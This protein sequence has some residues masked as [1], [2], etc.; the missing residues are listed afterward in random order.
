MTD[1]K[2]R[3]LVERLCQTVGCPLPCMGHE[4]TRKTYAV[5]VTVVLSALNAEES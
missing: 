1:A 4:E 3:E 2:V 5:I